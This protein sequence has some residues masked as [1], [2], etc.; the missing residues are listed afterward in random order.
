MG[1]IFTR[2]FDAVMHWSKARHSVKAL[3]TLSFLESFVFPVPPDVLL[4]PLCISNQKRAFYFAF[5]TTVF[6]VFG[7]VIG[8][9]FGMFFSEFFLRTLV[10]V[11]DEQNI[12]KISQLLIEWGVLI[13]LI[14]GFSP[15][16]YKVFTVASGVAGMAF[17]P[18]VIASFIG[19]GMRF[20]LIGFIISKGGNNLE[21]RI[22]KYA[23]LLGWFGVSII[24]FYLF[25]QILEFN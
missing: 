11:F 12:Y 25:F 8:H 5:I 14:S 4:I 7:G 22:R 9:F 3:S 1:R 19:R 18:F 10:W 17:F 2:L 13:V 23:E 21:Q 6:S 20:F 24:F 15:I 16:P